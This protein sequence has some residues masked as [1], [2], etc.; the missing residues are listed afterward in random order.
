MNVI[1]A[2]I[3]AKNITSHA[4]YVGVK[5]DNGWHR[6]CWKTYLYIDGIQVYECDYSKGMAF[7]INDTPTTQEI[8]VGMR[9]DEM[10]SDE[11]FEGWCASF[12]YDEDSRKAFAIYEACQK[13]SQVYQSIFTIEEQ[14]QISE[15]IDDEGL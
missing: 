13:V 15:Y 3:Q 9:N 12:G 4:Q 14:T 11:T 5:N 6:H 10:H 7:S 8:I 1:E 2:L